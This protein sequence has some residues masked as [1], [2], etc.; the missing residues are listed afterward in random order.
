MRVLHPASLWNLS[1]ESRL[2]TTLWHFFETFSWTRTLL[3][4]TRISGVAWSQPKASKR[5]PLLMAR[6]LHR[7][8][9]NKN[10][11]AY[12]WWRFLYCR[13]RFNSGRRWYPMAISQFPSLT[14]YFSSFFYCIRGSSKRFPCSNMHKTK[15][16]SSEGCISLE[17]QDPIYYSIFSI[18]SR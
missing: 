4:C 11:K 12:V 6:V 3:S 7:K 14:K 5:R 10:L 8:G 16:I 15:P 13:C 9:W 18:I 17:Y 1:H 2:S